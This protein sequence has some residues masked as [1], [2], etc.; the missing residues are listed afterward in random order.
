M[1]V[2]NNPIILVRKK[3]AA[4]PFKTIA[5]RRKIHGFSENRHLYKQPFKKEAGNNL[6][7]FWVI[8]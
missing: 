1:N 3:R 4:L 5:P 6:T 2:E 7:S 8:D